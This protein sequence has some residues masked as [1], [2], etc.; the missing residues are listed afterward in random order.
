M[1]EATR[2]IVAAVA[3]LALLPGGAAW[4]TDRAE[5]FAIEVVDA[6]TGRGVPLVV[7]E[8][9]DNRQYVTDSAGLVALDHPAFFGERVFFRVTGHGYRFPADGFGIRG[10]A[11]RVEPG[12]TARLEVERINIAERLYRITGAGIYEHAVRLERPTPIDRP[13]LNAGVMGQDSV[14]ATVY[15]G[16]VHWFW[17]DTNLPHYPLGVFQSTGA[18]SLLP[19]RGGL[20]PGVGTN[21]S[22]FRDENGLSRRMFET[23]QQYPV[24]IEG[25]CAVPDRNGRERLIAHYVQV[26]EL[27]K[28][29]AWGIAVWDDETLRFEPTVQLPGN[30]PAMLHGSQAT[31][32]EE[33]RR[34]WVYFA[35]PFPLVRVPATYEAVLDPTQYEAFTCLEG[36]AWWDDDAPPPVARDEEGNVVYA[37]RAGTAWVDQVRQARLV[38]TGRLGANEGWLDVR[39][40]ENGEPIRLHRGS[41]NWSPYR[42]RWIMIGGRHGGEASFLGDIYYA[43]AEAPEG[44]WPR[45]RRIVMHVGHSF[46]NPAHHPFF[47]EEDG[48]VIYFEGTYTILFSDAVPTPGYEYNQILY[49]LD[50]S[51]PRLHDDGD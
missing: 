13:L 47:D 6:Q 41:V 46:Y 12:G 38:E 36:G 16:Q 43:E 39:D 32:V 37:W 42:G 31:L 17:G 10:R 4:G 33:E 27:G 11:L 30:S 45:A 29:R 15:R 19:N 7:L 25:L 8:T 40:A 9:T 2:G 23:E 22:Y 18:T 48:R 49:R 20:D 3:G 14:Q 21:L 35:A 26:E 44:P 28:P 51:D 34:R 24:W 1:L 50:L 5:P